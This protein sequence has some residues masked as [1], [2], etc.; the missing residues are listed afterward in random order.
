MVRWWFSENCSRKDETRRA[1]G[2]VFIRAGDGKY[3]YKSA[4]ASWRFSSKSYSPLIIQCGDDFCTVNVY[5][6]FRLNLSSAL[7]LYSLLWSSPDD[8]CW[9]FSKKQTVIYLDW[10]GITKFSQ[11]ENV[12][13]FLI[14]LTWAVRVKQ[15]LQAEN[16]PISGLKNEERR[17][18][19]KKKTKKLESVWLLPGETFP[20]QCLTDDMFGCNII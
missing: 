10:S 15:T 11:Q 18:L 9:I 5:F 12:N 1:S 7:G 8:S 20:A 6:R 13:W 2:P 4:A 3:R 19:F 17:R 14:R 16:S